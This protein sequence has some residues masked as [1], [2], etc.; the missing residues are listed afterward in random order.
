MEAV[1]LKAN[2]SVKVAVI[3]AGMVVFQFMPALADDTCFA[4]SP[5][6]TCHPVGDIDPTTSRQ[7]GD[8]YKAYADMVWQGFVALNWPAAVGPDGKLQPIPSTQNA[9]DYQN[10]VYTTV[11]ET[12]IEARDLFPP[13]GAV[14]KAFGSGHQLPAAC[15]NLDAPEEATLLDRIAK[16]DTPESTSVPILDEY[17]QAN[18]MGP[19]VDINGF[20]VRFGINFNKDMYAYVV[21]NNLY[22]AKGQEVFDS[23][24]L[25]RDKNLVN[26]PRGQYQT[27]PSPDA[28]GSIMLKSS[29]RILTAS[30]DPAMYHTVQ[31]YIYNPAYGIL[32][33]E[34][35]V[36]ESCTLETVGML[37]LHI[38]QRTNS[39]PQWI[40]ATFEHTDNAP[41]IIDF[42]EGTPAGPFALFDPSTC[43]P[44]NGAPSCAYNEL[45]A[46]PW[47]P[48]S[49]DPKSTQVVR[50]AAP[51][52]YAQLANKD[53][54]DKLV[55]RFGNTPWPNYF[56]VDV[57]FPTNVT[58]TDS[59]TGFAQINPAY[60]DG[61]PT[62]TFLANSTMETYIQGF[63]NLRNATPTTSNG[64]VISRWDQMQNIG[65]A[66]AVDPFAPS[67]YSKS[68]GAQRSTSSCIA[69][70]GDATLVTGSSGSFVFSLSRAE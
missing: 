42:Q 58:I 63:P 33:Q 24:N 65:E 44:V 30:D 10:G 35:T 66:R 22:S 70:H 60:P 9:L 1:L 45:P 25:Y 36:P 19:V 11:W 68:G 23:V 61:L 62:P 8:L 37:G 32:G 16:T 54:H 26:W 38:V 46:H 4:T 29:W 13:N 56:L 21:D 18:R 20:Y 3:A 34:P 69:C 53:W 2:L 55:R 64:N 50:I 15:A 40:W 39:S 51:G 28:T 7:Y 57:Q 47:S 41:W 5:P 67:I 43:Q 31:A 52:E 12:Y 17:I 27:N 59:S 48:N 6:Y 49:T 14:P